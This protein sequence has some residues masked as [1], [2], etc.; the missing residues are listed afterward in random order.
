MRMHLERIKVLEAE[1]EKLEEKIRN[2]EDYYGYDKLCQKYEAQK[3]EKQ[4]AIEM[5]ERGEN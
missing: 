4:W 2:R 5:Y 3:Q 1:I